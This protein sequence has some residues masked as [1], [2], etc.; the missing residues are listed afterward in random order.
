MRQSHV[1]FLGFS[2][3]L[4]LGLNACSTAPSHAP[5]DDRTSRPPSTESAPEPRADNRIK[6]E[7]VIVESL[8]EQATIEAITPPTP[9]KQNPAV[10]ALLASAQQS[11]DNGNLP[12]AQ[13]QLQRAQR[14]APSDPEV[15]YSLAQTH[16]A[17][18]NYGL[19]EQV[20]L[21]GIS[22]ANGQTDK[23]KKLWFLMAKIKLR[24]GDANGAE[25]AQRKA[26]S[27]L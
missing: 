10:I 9:K 21:K 16:L 22:V 12:A 20:T 11:T 15:Y 18:D 3:F 24:A 5:I 17:L 23:L 25:E 1:R 8:P 27:Y 2:A 4:L 6:N 13:N 19:A 14:I 26:Q 7:P